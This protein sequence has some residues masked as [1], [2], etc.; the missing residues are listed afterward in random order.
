[1]ENG[2][3]KVF[4]RAWYWFFYGWVNGSA[5]CGS[6]GKC[7]VSFNWWGNRPDTS[8]KANYNILSTDYDNY[9]I[10]YSCFDSSSGSKYENAW[11]M[12]REPSIKQEKL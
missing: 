11:I 9:T 1:M 10:V 7:M 5:T 3:I 2:D 8:K 6:D 4:N 12:T